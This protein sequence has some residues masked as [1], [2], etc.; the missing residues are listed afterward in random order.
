MK[1]YYSPEERLQ[2]VMDNCARG[3]QVEFC[4]KT[5]LLASTVS[6]VRSGQL[7]LSEDR[8]QSICSAYPAVNP[9]FLRDGISYPGDISIEIVKARLEEEIKKRDNLIESLQKQLKLDQRIIAR[10][11]KK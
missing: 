5:G 6:R 10:L 8:I 2:F 7:K 3:N 11:T 4:Q 9:Q 1:D